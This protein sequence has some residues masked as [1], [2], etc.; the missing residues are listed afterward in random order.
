MR[1]RRQAEPAEASVPLWQYEEAI[2]DAGKFQRQAQ[3][4]MQVGKQTE[5]ELTEEL[6]KLQ[7]DL[8]F[9][10]KVNADL[11]FALA[12]RDHELSQI[13]KEDC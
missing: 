10:E 4:L 7:T 1:R 9:L 13:K 2:E 3:R 6:F 8:A 11:A 12:A 5:R